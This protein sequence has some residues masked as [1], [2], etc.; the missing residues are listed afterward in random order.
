MNTAYTLSINHKV[1]LFDANFGKS[2]IYEKLGFPDYEYCFEHLMRDSPVNINS[3]NM[4]LTKANAIPISSN[5]YNLFSENLYFTRLLENTDTTTDMTQAGNILTLLTNVFDYIVIDLSLTRISSLAMSLFSVCDKA[6]IVTTQDLYDIN[7]ISRE[8]ETYK[9]LIHDKAKICVNKYC[10]NVS[11]F[12]ND[13]AQFFKLSECYEIKG[14]NKG[15][16]EASTNG[17]IYSMTGKKKIKAD[18]Q[19]MFKFKKTKEGRRFLYGK[20]K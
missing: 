13:I 11:P 1:L 3:Y 7:K 4:C 10:S 17:Y 2:C 19:K 5:R 12:S 18:Y 16:I 15:F 8:Y 9:N 20:R 14:D 6:V